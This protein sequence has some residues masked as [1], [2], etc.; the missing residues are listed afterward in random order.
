MNQNEIAELVNSSVQS[1]AELIVNC[2]ILNKSNQI[3]YD[4]KVRYDEQFVSFGIK[5]KDFSIS[6]EMLTMTFMLS[7]FEFFNLLSK[8]KY[9]ILLNRI[10]KSTNSDHDYDGSF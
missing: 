10:E 8:A 7:D 1:N 2:L 6:T 4:I 9:Q 3:V 5:Y